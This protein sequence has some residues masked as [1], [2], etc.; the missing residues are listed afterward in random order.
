MRPEERARGRDWAR[1]IGLVAP[2]D[3]RPRERPRRD[4]GL[5]LPAKL[6]RLTAPRRGTMRETHRRIGIPLSRSTIIIA[7]RWSP[8]SYA[9][10]VASRRVVVFSTHSPT[11]LGKTSLLH[12]NRIHRGSAPTYSFNRGYVIKLLR[13]RYA[14]TL[15]RDA[16]RVTRLPR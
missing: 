14:I 11:Y 13:L 16:L 2:G 4:P 7:R 6:L 15:Q 8:V 3:P 9:W 10:H 5:L 12:L 1:E